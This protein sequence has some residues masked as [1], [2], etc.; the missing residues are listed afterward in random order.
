MKRV[1]F[2]IA[3]LNQPQQMNRLLNPLRLLNLMNLVIRQNP[4]KA[5]KRE[6]QLTTV[7]VL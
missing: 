1:T 2:L 3:I 6:L 5:E 4:M 7:S